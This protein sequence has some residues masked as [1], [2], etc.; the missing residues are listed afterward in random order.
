MISQVSKNVFNRLEFWL[1]GWMILIIAY[2]YSNIN[3]L[4]WN[5]IT[6]SIQLIS[7]ILIGLYSFLAYKAQNNSTCRFFYLLIFLSLIPGLA[8]N[9]L[10]NFLNYVFVGTSFS[11][12]IQAL[13]INFY[14]IFLLIEICAWS[15]LLYH[16]NHSKQPNFKKKY[17]MLNIPY[18]IAL[19]LILFSFYLVK[20]YMIGRL[21]INEIIHSILEIVFFILLSLCL[22]RAKNKSLIYLSTGYLLLTAFNLAQRFSYVSGHFVKSFDI[23]WLICLTVIIFGLKLAWDKKS[24]NISFFNQGSIHIVIGSIFIFLVT[25]V[26]GVF[27]LISLTLS[28]IDVGNNEL[29]YLL[30]KNIP[31]VLIFSYT[32]ALLGSKLASHYVSRPIKLILDKIQNTNVN[33]NLI[34]NANNYIY[35]VDMLDHLLCQSINKLQ[36]ANA[37]KSDFLMNMSHDFRTPASGI[38]HLAKFVHERLEIEELKRLQQLIIDSSEQL[39]KFLEEILSYT[40]NESGR[41]EITNELVNLQELVDEN[42]LLLA[43]K[44]EGKGLYIRQIMAAKPIMIYTDHLILSRIILNILSNA[45]KF[46][47]T[48]GVTISFHEEID[49][50]MIQINDTGIG[51][52]EKYHHKIF[53]PFFKLSSSETAKYPGIGL[54]LSNV[55]LM[56]SAIAVNIELESHPGK[57]TSFKIFLFK[58]DPRNSE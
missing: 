20:D 45:V 40:R 26:I 35:E 23:F 58:P 51:I 21:G 30:F 24:S 46:T 15:Y 54:G 6:F 25:L 3:Q 14:T 10:Y 2:N 7:D 41:F 27:L 34:P 50:V 8:C 42:I 29:K 39:I 44:A 9:E 55:K 28:S 5:K 52:D 22:C 18:F 43:V 13:Y 19:L 56:A 1:V 12:S 36:S 33:S 16:F 11:S 48:G 32:L 4:Y 49:Y 37:V 38:F 57:G 31:A 47:E 53:E 17:L